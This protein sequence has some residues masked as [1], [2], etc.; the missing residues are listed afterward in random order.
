MATDYTSSE[1]R[2]KHNC[3]VLFAHWERGL[4]KFTVTYLFREVSGLGLSIRQPQSPPRLPGA[5]NNHGNLTPSLFLSFLLHNA[6]MTNPPTAIDPGNDLVQH[7][8]ALNLNGT[9][10]PLQWVPDAYLSM[11]AINTA[12]DRKFSPS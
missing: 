10:A 4:N 11:T 12:F 1:D 7:L 6:T 5:D 2:N 9:L 8:R 3:F